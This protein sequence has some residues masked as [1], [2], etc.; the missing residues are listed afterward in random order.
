MH[1]SA[2]ERFDTNIRCFIETMVVRARDAEARGTT[3]RRENDGIVPPRDF[4]RTEPPC[5]ASTFAPSRLRG[6][7]RSPSRSGEIYDRTLA[8][9]SVLSLSL[10]LVKKRY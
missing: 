5:N 10:S 8:S 1:I 7:L 3:R 9:D 2:A 6:C 4:H